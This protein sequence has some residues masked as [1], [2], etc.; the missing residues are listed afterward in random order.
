M[1]LFSPE[2]IK[3]ARDCSIDNEIS[4]LETQLS[5]L[6]ELKAL[7]NPQTHYALDY[8]GDEPNVTAVICSC[9]EETK[10]KVPLTS[11]KDF[12]CPK[13]GK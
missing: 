9:G 6:K 4:K 11:L 13:K 2:L 5:F 12:E 8:R 1:S 3:L 10:Y 7:R